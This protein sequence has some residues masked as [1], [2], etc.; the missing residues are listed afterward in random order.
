YGDGPLSD[1]LKT[2]AGSQ[3]AENYI[4]F[5][6][7]CKNIA[8]QLQTLDAL[9]MT[10]DHEGLPMVLLEAMCMK[11]PIIAHAIGGIPHL[12]DNGQCGTLIHE[13]N[14]SSF[15]EAIIKLIAQ[16]AQ[17]QQLAE[18][19]FK[20]IEQHYSATQNALTYLNIYHQITAYNSRVT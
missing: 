12:L 5:E 16:P 11:T 20:R 8:E 15:A 19:A 4:H 2:Q 6:G 1:I 14:A 17:H 9:L 18:R 10:S 13:H 3:Q 7:H